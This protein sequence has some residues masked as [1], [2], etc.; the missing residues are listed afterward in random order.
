MNGSFR[1]RQ[2]IIILLVLLVITLS[3]LL[4]NLRE[5]SSLNFIEKAIVGALAPFQ[6]AV[7]WTAARASMVWDD[8]IHL[9][10]V[11]QE[12]KELKLRARRLAFENSLLVEKLKFYRRLDKLLTF[13]MLDTTR[14]EAA[15]VIGRDTTDRV[16]LITINKGEKNG[17]GK[18][19]PVV[20]HRGLVGRVISSSWG[21][22][23]VLLITDV[24]SAIDGIMQKSRDSVV[25]VGANSPLLEAKYLAVGADVKDGDR[26][27]SS[28]LGG[29]F[30][31]GLVI[32][33]LTNVRIQRDSLF[34]SARLEPMA[35][36]NK[37]EE[38]LVL[39]GRIHAAEKE[40]EQK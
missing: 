12:N 37:L 1:R 26:V 34:L 22:A 28:G 36:L 5:K 33:E 6:D 30:P 23:K 39:K 11:R 40:S 4:T 13:P 15:R 20:T 10:N 14:F 3:I 24:R 9:V 16:K 21:A 18:D 38:V 32:G 35:D 31:K 27:I 29:V 19:M 7:G 2:D 8:Y 25:I 17:V